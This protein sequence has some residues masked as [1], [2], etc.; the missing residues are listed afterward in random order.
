MKN[1]IGVIGTMAMMA[2]IEAANRRNDNIPLFLVDD[3]LLSSSVNPEKLKEAKHI[4]PVPKVIPNGCKEYFFNSAGEF[5]TTKM[6]KTECVFT[7]YAINDK[8]AIKKFKTQNTK[9][10]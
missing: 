1:K 4:P 8:N 2:A 9:T 10:K 7:C 5:S 3:D 6:L